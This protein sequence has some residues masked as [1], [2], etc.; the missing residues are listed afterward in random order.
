M[1]EKVMCP[2]IHH[3]IDSHGFSDS[4]TS[5][6]ET[7]QHLKLALYRG[8]YDRNTETLE[9]RWVV[10]D[11]HKRIGDFYHQ[12]DN[13]IDI[14]GSDAHPNN[15]D[16][17]HTLK[18][19]LLGKES[20]FIRT[21]QL[22]TDENVYGLFVEKV[23]ITEKT[24]TEIKFVG[25][26]FMVP[27]CE[28]DIEEGDIIRQQLLESLRKERE[29]NQAKELFINMVSHEM[30]TPLAVIQGAVDLIEHCNDKLS[31][32]DKENYMQSIRRA[33]LRMTRTM[34]AVLILSKVQSNQLSFQPLE[35]DVVL[36][37][38]NIIN[39]IENLNEG[40]KIVLQISK[41]FPRNIDID[42]TL[43]YHIISNLL[44]NAIKY[45]DP[46][47]LVYLN[48]VYDGETLTIYVRDSGIGIPHKELKGIFKLFHRGAN[49]K[50][51]KGMGIG[52]FIIKH[53]IALHNGSI[54]VESK[55]HEG[56]TFRVKLPIAHRN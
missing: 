18:N 40:R 43:L 37:C 22:L 17:V 42:T 10:D 16:L 45:S 51:R 34:D 4:A 7:C 50:G 9:I 6:V 44:N 21:Y 49:A 47:T 13:Y 11:V 23:R 1:V 41:S 29:I 15:V 53:C 20:S 46:M 25:C 12:S 39:E 3:T 32:G 14:V 8:N 27:E 26:L 33:I 55:E 31:D 36:F 2:L 30:R 38:K 5:T 35:S 24:E 48:L 19:K 28:N 52:M 54:E 56:T